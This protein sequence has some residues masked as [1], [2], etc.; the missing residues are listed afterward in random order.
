MS[1][2]GGARRSGLAGLDILA[3]ALVIPDLLERLTS[4]EEEEYCTCVIV[5]M[6][7]GDHDKQHSRA[8][9]FPA[10]FK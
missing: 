6:A 9:L 3:L 10:R 5:A 7:A 8:L 4:E 2:W 1:S